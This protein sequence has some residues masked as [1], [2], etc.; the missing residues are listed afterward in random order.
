MEI[1]YHNAMPNWAKIIGLKIKT[2]DP[3]EGG[4]FAV[5]REQAEQIV[6][7]FNGEIASAAH[8]KGMEEAAG[9]AE[10]HYDKDR[11][12][13]LSSAGRYIAAA[14]RAAMEKPSE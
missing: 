1:R 4:G 11:A 12:P 3:H 6:Q 13:S 8:R 7:L 2:V 14:I 10:N 9:I 5:D